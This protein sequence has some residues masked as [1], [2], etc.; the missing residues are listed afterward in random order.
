MIILN[1]LLSLQN[2]REREKRDTQAGIASVLSISANN[3]LFVS[4]NDTIRFYADGAIFISV[5]VS[6]FELPFLSS[7]NPIV[8]QKV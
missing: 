1:F 2:Q 6:N 5:K 3:I 8:K 7:N 4:L